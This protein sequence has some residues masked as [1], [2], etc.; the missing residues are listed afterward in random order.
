MVKKVYGKAEWQ[1]FRNEILDLVTLY[2]QVKEYSEFDK[3]KIEH[4]K[5]FFH[6]SKKQAITS[7]FIKVG[8]LVM[9]DG[10]PSLFHFLKEEEYYQLLQLYEPKIRVLRNKFYA[11]SDKSHEKLQIIT[12]TNEDIDELY[13]QIISSAKNIDQRFE[14][15]WI[16]DFVHNADGIKSIESLIDDSIEL[17]NLKSALVKNDFKANVELEIM[18]GKILILDAK[19]FYNEPLDKKD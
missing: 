13:A 18:N 17:H 9:K 4:I 3:D 1:E 12:L 8:F 5:S 14:D 6:L 19:E 16:Y 2:H 15:P 10:N 11:H 7:F